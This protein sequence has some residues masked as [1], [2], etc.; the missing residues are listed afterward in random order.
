MK[1]KWSCNNKETFPFKEAIVCDFDGTITE[2]DVCDE[3]MKKFGTLKWRYIGRKHEIG[4]ISHKVMNE[5]FVTSLRVLPEK[6]GEF[7]GKKIKIRKGFFEFLNLCQKHNILFVVVSSGWDF[8]IKNV[9]KDINLKFIKSADDLYQTSLGV[10]PVICNNILF[11]KKSCLWKIE[12]PNFGESQRSTPDK[13]AIV[14]ILRS[15]GV[16]NITV[17]G[18]SNNDRE[19]AMA[20]DFI[21]SRD[22]LTQYCVQENIN[23]II[24]SSF[25]DISKNVSKNIKQAIRILS[26]PSYHP[27]NKRFDN[28]REIIFV[29]PDCDFFADERNSS[30]KY[31]NKHFPLD[32]YDIVH[33]HFE[34]Y[35]IPFKIFKKLIQY[36]KDNNKPI[37]W[38]CHDR[39]SLLSQKGNEKYEKL[40]FDNADIITTLTLGCSKWLN[41]KFGKHR[42]AIKV[43]PHGYMAHPGI[44][45]AEAKTIK[46]DKNI[47]TMYVGDFRKNKEY[48]NSICDFLSCPQ[49][50]NVKLQVIFKP[51][52]IYKNDIE[53]A[54]QLKKFHD[55]IKHP[56]IVKICMSYIPDVVLI[57]AFLA[58]HAIILP[59]KWGTHSGQLELARDCGNYVIVS[60]VGFYKEQWSSIFEW[61]GKEKTYQQVLIDVYSRKSL[62]PAGYQRIGEFNKIINGHIKNYNKLIH[63]KIE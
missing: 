37:V 54:H 30:Q 22:K 10:V 18:N 52:N 26:L 15:F 58:S 46:K 45:E 53:V 19:M 62:E 29:N 51:I 6:L 40:L 14:N 35:Q 4:A 16:K 23:H 1:K 24:F 42:G 59:Y 27:Y 28:Q 39:N 38:T 56:R 2:K 17:V 41:L 48:I 32:A 25:I 12:F 20:A 8:Y 31:L 9:L 3:I 43:I 21:F 11:N 5:N 50:K 36:F 33:I 49:L 44:I 63:A 60:N 34:Y 57:R 55:L 13:R 7:I 61:D 47:F